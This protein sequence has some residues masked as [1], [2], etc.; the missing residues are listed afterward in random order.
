MFLSGHNGTVT[1]LS[2]S[3]DG[4]H[5]LSNSADN[6]V[7]MWD[8]RPYVSDNRCVGNFDGIQVAAS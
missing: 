1:G 7:K 2:L 3:P 6:T 5:L 4:N 8:I